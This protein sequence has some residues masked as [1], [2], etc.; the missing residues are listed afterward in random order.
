[1]ALREDELAARLALLRNWGMLNLS[2]LWARHMD[3][4]NVR[5]SF[6]VIAPA[7]VAVHKVQVAAALDAVDNY[8]LLK[9]A[10]NG[11]LY[12]VV[13]RNDRPDRPSVTAS[14]QSAQVYIAQAP[15]VVLGRIK[16][17]HKPA[18]ALTYGMNYLGRLFGSEAHQVGRDVTFW[19]MVDEVS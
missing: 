17:G 1:M 6:A 13:W 12:D 3:P 19:R 16:R 15:Y 9:A 14:G 4:D 2:V 18:A 7:L 5:D 11:M 10:D 8:M